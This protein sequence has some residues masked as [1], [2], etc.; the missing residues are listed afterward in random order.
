MSVG[1]S[2]EVAVLAHAELVRRRED[3]HLRFAS[4]RS[5]TT[6]ILGASGLAATLV[7]AVGDNGGYV[8]AVICYVFATVYSVKSMRLTALQGL[9]TEG[10]IAA[11][12]SLDEHA[13]R[14][15]IVTDI[16]V[17]LVLNEERL[18]AVGKDAKVA[19][20]WFLAGTVLTALV[21][22]ITVLL[23]IDWG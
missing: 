8:I 6:G 15:R 16:G 14:V 13:A 5:R 11:L 2:A 21:A 20:G 3:Q 12:K 22:A 10:L 18:H 7:S 4:V 23:S 17:Q 1:M 9:G 19:M